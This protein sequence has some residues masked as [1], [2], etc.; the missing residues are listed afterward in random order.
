[1]NINEINKEFNFEMIVRES[2]L[3]TF[4]HVNNAAYLQIFEEAR[5]DY[6]SAGGYTLDYV[7]QTQKG[8]IIL[9]INIKFMKEIQLREKIKVTIDLIQYTKKIGIL[10]QKIFKENGVLACEGQFTF[11]LFD[12]QERKLIAATKEWANAI[13]YKSIHA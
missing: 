4:G 2:L 5:W 9:E 8:P 1:M 3:D 6:I 12:L 13:A 10:V 11:G 7:K